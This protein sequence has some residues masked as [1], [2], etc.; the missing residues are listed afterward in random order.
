MA[1]G[2]ILF[3]HRIMYRRIATLKEE[4]VGKFT[5]EYQNFLRYTVQRIV[6][7]VTILI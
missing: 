3:L 5:K 2:I 1:I 4:H 6:E 7:H